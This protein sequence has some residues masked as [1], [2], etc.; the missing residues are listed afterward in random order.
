M[1]KRDKV[2]LGVWVT[3]KLDKQ[4]LKVALESHRSKA[5]LIRELLD[6]RFG[7][8]EVEEDDGDK[9]TSEQ[10]PEGTN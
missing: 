5:F 10:I 4:I 2:M 9:P 3:K 7:T 6:A 1:A 8:I